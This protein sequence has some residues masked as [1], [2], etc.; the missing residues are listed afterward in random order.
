METV[1]LT[2]EENE[3]L[4]KYRKDVESLPKYTEE[5]I[6]EMIVAVAGGNVEKKTQLLSAML[7]KIEEIT[8]P[9]WGKGVLVDDLVQEGNLALLLSIELIAANKTPLSIDTLCEQILS[10]VKLAVDENLKETEG[11]KNVADRLNK[12]L[13]AIDYFTKELEQE[14]DM[15]ELSAYLDMPVQEIEDLLKM[16]GQELGEEEMEEE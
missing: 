9:L 12:L 8:K 3:F 2:T 7:S 6:E 14:I 11:E 10:A 16:A 13:D 5:Q 4:K 1:K 15:D